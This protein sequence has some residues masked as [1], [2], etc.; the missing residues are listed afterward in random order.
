MPSNMTPILSNVLSAAFAAVRR[1]GWMPMAVFFAHELCAHVIGGYRRWPSVDIPLHFFG[2]FAIAYFLAGALRVFEKR[3]LLR[4]SDPW[5]RLGLLFG[6]VTTSAVFWEFAEWIADH[7]LGTRC[8]LSVDDTIL[9]LLMGVL[10]GIVFLM[11]RLLRALTSS[12]A[13]DSKP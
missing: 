6:L 4:P 2:G 9:D 11:P 10:G 12:P 8:Q 5:V 3:R 7:T 13:P 1:Y